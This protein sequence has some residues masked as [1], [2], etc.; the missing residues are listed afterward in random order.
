MFS[1]SIKLRERQKSLGDSA[2]VYVKVMSVTEGKE[3]LVGE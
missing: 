3:S 1:G 2:S